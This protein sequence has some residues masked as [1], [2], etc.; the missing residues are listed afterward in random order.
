MNY[1]NSSSLVVWV[2]VGKS[3]HSGAFEPGDVI[4]LL[5]APTGVA[6]FNTNSMTL[7]SALL[8]GRSKYGGLPVMTD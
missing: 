8:L 6:A 2:Y 1:E 3:H 7:H 4:L 5:T